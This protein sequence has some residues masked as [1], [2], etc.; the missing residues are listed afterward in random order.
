MMNKEFLKFLIITQIKRNMLIFERG[1][2]Y[3]KEML[4]KNKEVY[5]KNINEKENLIKKY[6]N[7]LA[8]LAKVVNE[9]TKKDSSNINEIILKQWNKAKEYL[10]TNPTLCDTSIYTIFHNS[11][12]YGDEEFYS[13]YK[14]YYDETL[15]YGQT[16]EHKNSTFYANI[17]F[18]VVMKEFEFLPILYDIVD[19]KLYNPNFPTGNSLE[20]FWTMLP[21]P[22]D[23]KELSL[24]KYMEKVVLDERTNYYILKNGSDSTRILLPPSPSFSGLKSLS[25]R[26][27]WNLE[28]FSKI[29]KERNFSV[30]DSVRFRSEN[31]ST[32]YNNY[33][34]LLE[35]LFE[36]FQNEY[37]VVRDVKSYLLSRKGINEQIKSAT[38]RE[39]SRND[40]I[41]MYIDLIAKEHGNELEEE[42]KKLQFL[43]F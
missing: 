22:Y 12:N 4:D 14:I 8:R 9:V 28:L 24:L 30:L 41:D 29:I 17:A 5:L 25:D 19:Y 37:A 13:L 2:S 27:N 31:S 15:V 38:Y 36:D 11:G 33:R 18:F 43:K 20:P 16:D 3:E 39:P 21:N 35:Y 10:L 23:L 40:V 6:D 7:E 32:Y 26:D 34:S 1:I 42:I